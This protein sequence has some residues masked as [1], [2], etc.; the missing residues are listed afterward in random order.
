[1]RSLVCRRAH[2]SNTPSVLRLTCDLPTKGLYESVV[3]RDGCVLPGFPALQ[4]PWVHAERLGQT[5]LRHTEHLSDRNYALR[6]CL[7]RGERVISQK[8][9]DGRNV[10]D[11]G[12]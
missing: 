9:E 6:K 1:M 11:C 10:S 7:A 2:A 3:L 4:G 8:V 5:P 12:R